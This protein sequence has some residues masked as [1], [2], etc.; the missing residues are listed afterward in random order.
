METSGIWEAGGP[1]P[2]FKKSC[3]KQAFIFP[4][5]SGEALAKSEDEAIAK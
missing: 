3:K 4:A 1:N 2:L 5:A